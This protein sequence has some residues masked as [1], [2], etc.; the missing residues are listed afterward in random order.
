MTLSRV[1]YESTI[2]QGTDEGLDLW[3]AHIVC[4]NEL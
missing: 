4:L 2:L 3:E 1:E